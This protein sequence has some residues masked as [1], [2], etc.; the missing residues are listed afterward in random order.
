MCLHYNLITFFSFVSGLTI[1]EHAMD[2]SDVKNLISQLYTDLNI[3]HHQ[4]ERE[5]DLKA[6]LEQLQLE[7][8]PLEEVSYLI[9]ITGQIIYMGGA[10]LIK[11]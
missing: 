9:A 6:K 1:S 8:Q 7:L 3:E 5:R 10:I 2:V 11:L 4:L